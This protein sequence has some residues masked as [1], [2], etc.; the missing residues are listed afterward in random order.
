MRKDLSVDADIKK[1]QNI[2]RS[3]KSVNQYLQQRIFSDVPLE[4]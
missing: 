1:N 2:I 4:V 3:D